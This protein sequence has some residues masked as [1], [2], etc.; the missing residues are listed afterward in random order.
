MQ[1]GPGRRHDRGMELQP[2]RYESSAKAYTGFFA[3]GFGGGGPAPGLLGIHEGGGLT[4]HTKGRA[5]RLAELGFVAFA[6]GL[7]GAEVEL[8]SPERPESL[9]KAQALVRALRDDVAE[10]RA[11]VVAALAVL[12][13]H[14][15]V[16]PARLAAISYCLG[17]APAVELPRTGAP[18]TAVAGFHAGILPGSAAD[19]NRIAGK[20][21]LCHGAEARAV[22][23]AQIHDFSAG[24]TAAGVDWQVHVYGGVGHS[25]TN[26]LID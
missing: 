20:V 6:M 19:D 16:D 11:R 15:H 18:L 12:Q 26:P 25:F 8:P 3:D 4:E 14:A 23:F 9:A 13:R 17:G 24:L 1:I 10:F 2:I 21:L 7:F 22:L 5:L